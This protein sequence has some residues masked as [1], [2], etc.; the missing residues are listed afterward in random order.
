MILWTRFHTET[1]K[2]NTFASIS[3]YAYICRCSCY[4]EIGLWKL[5]KSSFF[6]FYG[7]LVL[8]F[9]LPRRLRV[10]F[11]H[12]WTHVRVCG[13]VDKARGVIRHCEKFFQS[14]GIVT[15]L[16]LSGV[17]EEVRAHENWCEGRP[18]YHKNS[19]WKKWSVGTEEK[20]L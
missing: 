7:T 8:F 12:E 20:W 14:L 6:P 13:A 4:S 19:L 1:V 15:T 3:S 10:L 17:H 16:W 18:Y 11:C 2:G 5:L 9:D